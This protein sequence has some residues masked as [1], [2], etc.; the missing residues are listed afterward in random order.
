MAD[1]SDV[2]KLLEKI[3][4]GVTE[5]VVAD[6]GQKYTLTDAERRVIDE[7][8]TE[9]VRQFSDNYLGDAS[10]IT[11]LQDKKEHG[12]NPVSRVGGS[13]LPETSAK[14]SLTMCRLH[15]NK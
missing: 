9:K 3:E 7:R 5:R 4:A 6:G 12:S 14:K 8:M 1:K 13:P 15:F 10:Q 2:A 11:D